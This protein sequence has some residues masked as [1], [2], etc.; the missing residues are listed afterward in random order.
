IG[1][2]QDERYVVPAL[3]RRIRVAKKASAPAVRVGNIDVV[4]ELM[5]VDDV[6]EAYSLL[7]TRGKSGEVY[8][9]ASGRVVSLEDLFY[10]LCDTVGYRALPEPHPSLMRVGD[11]PYLVGD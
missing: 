7:L 9:V 8:N 6:V 3:A 10:R 4:R 2:G 5:H 11:I 1:P